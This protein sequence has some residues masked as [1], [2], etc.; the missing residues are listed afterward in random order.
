M[1]VGVEW[2]WRQDLGRVCVLLFLTSHSGV[3]VCDAMG[4]FQTTQASEQAV[5]LE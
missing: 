3:C 2:L 4:E 5:A 1:S